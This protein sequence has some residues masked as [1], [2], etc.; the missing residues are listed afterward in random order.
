MQ[1]KPVIGL[2]KSGISLGGSGIKLGATGIGKSVLKKHPFD[3]IPYDDVTDEQAATE[4]M[5]IAEEVLNKPRDNSLA[6]ERNSFTAMTDSEYWCCLCFQ[7]REQKERFLEAM[8]WMQYGDKYIDGYDIAKHQGI[9]LPES[10][11]PNKL[12]KSDP[13][14]NSLVR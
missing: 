12:A 3:E 8:K 4:E 5:R 2:A 10:D 14:W 11:A 7:T 1:K 6:K 9:E 13:K